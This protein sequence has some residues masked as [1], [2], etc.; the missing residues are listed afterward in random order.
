MDGDL[1]ALIL[2]AVQHG[3]CHEVTHLAFARPA[4]RPVAVDRR[5][6]FSH[7]ARFQLFDRAGQLRNA[8]FKGCILGD[9]GAD[10]DGVPAGIDEVARV[11]ESQLKVAKI[12]GIGIGLHDR[13][14]R[15]VFLA[16]KCGIGAS[17]L[18]VRGRQEGVGMPPH[19]S[20]EARHCG[21]N[22]KILAQAHMGQGD[23]LVDTHGL[24]FSHIGC[25]R[26]DLILEGDIRARAGGFSRVRGQGRNDPDLFAAHFQHNGRGDLVAQ[27]V[28]CGQIK[29]ARNHRE[30]HFV[31]ECRQRFGPV[32]EL[33]VANGH[34]IEP[35]R[36][37]HLGFHV[38][39]VGG[40]HQRAF[41]LVTRIECHH[42]LA[43]QLATLGIDQCL[44]AGHTAKALAF[45][46]ILCAAGT[47]EPA[48]GLDP[49]VQIIDVKN[50]QRVFCLRHARRHGQR[51][52]RA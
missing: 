3:I 11:I 23:D 6:G 17:A 1:D 8:G 39:L 16:G 46:V 2:H 38:T 44:E 15:A 24:E 13:H 26:V 19:H 47:I 21:C 7:N 18:G 9:F 4:I 52:S 22:F 34:G 45:C 36:F 35:D 37:H 5:S 20:V 32:I 10:K 40:V 50:M 25:N 49:A 31:D 27:Q 48:D 29:V 30:G 42:I 51:G 41:E 33:V 12:L 14:Q 43:C 28:G